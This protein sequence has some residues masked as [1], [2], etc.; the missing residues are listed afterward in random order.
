MNELQKKKKQEELKEFHAIFSPMVLAKYPYFVSLTSIKR[1]REVIYEAEENGA[2]VKWIVKSR[3]YLP[4]EMELKVWI[5]IL[6]K[7]SKIPKPLPSNFALPYSL[8]EITKY[9][10]MKK[11]GKLFSLIVRAIENLRLT[12]IEYWVEKPGS[13]PVR[14][15]F[16]LLIGEAGKGEKQ[17]EVIIDKN[18][19]F[20]HPNVINLINQGIIKP[21]NLEES[22]FLTDTNLIA[23]RIYE[24]LGWKFYIAKMSGENIV[25][26]RYSELVKRVELRQEKHRSRAA[27]Q[28][29]IPHK[30]LKDRGL[31]IEIP[32]NWKSVNGDWVI[33]Y[34]IGERLIKELNEWN[35]KRQI[36]RHIKQLK[37]E[38]IVVSD[39]DYAIQQILEF[40]KGG[41]RE[42]FEGLV[43]KIL[44][45]PDG[46]ELV[47]RAISEAKAEVING[48]IKNKT[49]YLITILKKYI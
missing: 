5:W 19:L 32:Q 38:D 7:I 30:L 29:K 18:F 20:F 31:I 4:G 27:Q 39:V 37:E 21:A 23:F 11:S 9:W 36:Q 1:K 16:S 25:N 26:M 10:N 24:L 48:K 8:S 43:R 28:L 45:K 42:D 33:T 6:D 22:K 49:A 44:Q 15:T 3:D 34:K 13:P 12:G 41:K 40:T 2:K 47:Y 46:E 14:I 17:G 35:N